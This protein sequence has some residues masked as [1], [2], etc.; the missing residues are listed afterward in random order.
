MFSRLMNCVNQL[1]N[2]KLIW[3]KGLELLGDGFLTKNLTWL[4]WVDK[5]LG[6]SISNFVDDI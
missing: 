2:G 6:Q 5:V 4:K 3:L 1:R